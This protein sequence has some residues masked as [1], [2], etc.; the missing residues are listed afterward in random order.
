MSHQD[1]EQFHNTAKEPG[2]FANGSVN[3]GDQRWEGSYT[4]KVCDRLLAMFPDAFTVFT[5]IAGG[6][7]Y[8]AVKQASNLLKDYHKTQHIVYEQRDAAQRELAKI[9]AELARVR[10]Q[11]DLGRATL[12]RVQNEL[13]LLKT[14]QPNTSIRGSIINAVL[15]D[16]AF[17]RETLK[18][19]LNSFG[20]GTAS[21]LAEDQLLPFFETAV[22]YRAQDELKVQIQDMENRLTAKSVAIDAVTRNLGKSEERVKNLR[23]LLS[24]IRSLTIASN[25]EQYEKT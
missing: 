2:K 8:D 12:T 4:K 24:R 3:P 1:Y 13:T 22:Y 15:K 7:L 16:G 25:A 18:R 20:V 11:R 9:H 19:A 21:N 6:S 5:K 23:Y 14:Q 17:T 10:E